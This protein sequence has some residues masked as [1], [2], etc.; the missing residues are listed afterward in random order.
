MRVCVCLFVYVWDRERESSQN[1]INNQKMKINW[2][3][4]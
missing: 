3:G 1:K 2:N 4:F